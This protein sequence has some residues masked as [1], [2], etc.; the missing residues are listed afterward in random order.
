MRGPWGATAIAVGLVLLVGPLVG[1]VVPSTRT[2]AGP[3]SIAG[4]AAD[5]ALAAT[6]IASPPAPPPGA[7]AVASA[8]PSL[9]PSEVART[10]FVNYN[11][12]VPGGFASTVADWYL[13]PGAYV[14][15]DGRLWLPNLIDPVRDP[16]PPSAPAVLYDPITNSFTGTVPAL[17][18]CSDFVYD[19]QNGYLYATQPFTDTVGVFNPANGSWAAPPIPVGNDPLRMVFDPSTQEMLVANALSDNL[20]VVNTTTESVQGSGV[21]LAASPDGMVLDPA[22]S[23]LFVAYLNSTDLTVLNATDFSPIA[24]PVLPGSAGGIAFSPTADRVGVTIRSKGYVSLLSASNYGTY[25]V[26]SVGAAPGAIA[27]TTDGESF[28]VGNDTSNLL[29]IVNATSGTVSPSTIQTGTAPTSFDQIGLGVYAWATVTH[30]LTAVWS[31]N[32]S[33]SIP[34]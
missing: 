29:T 5:L 33:E 20:T 26:V 17:T 10:L 25:G 28:L 1:G 16:V 15:S 31:G 6:P 32:A 21:V 12:S 13:G 2:A 8:H 14:P 34:S 3:P 30:V 27:A 22:N 9:T 19:P 4:L 7:S 24:T 23:T 11:A 18:N